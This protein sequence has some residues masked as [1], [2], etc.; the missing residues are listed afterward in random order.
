AAY[1]HEQPP[2]ATDPGRRYGAAMF[3]VDRESPA[4]LRYRGLP[5]PDLK[6]PTAGGHVTR[7]LRQAGRALTWTGNASAVG[8]TDGRKGFSP[9]PSKAVCQG[10]TVLTVQWTKLRRRPMAICEPLG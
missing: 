9:G 10:P 7:R 4:Q 3:R 2:P 5:L 6:R 1:S 8:P